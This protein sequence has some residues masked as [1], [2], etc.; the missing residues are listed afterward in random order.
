[1][2]NKHRHPLI[3][4][5]SG[6]PGWNSCFSFFSLNVFPSPA[7]LYNMLVLSEMFFLNLFFKLYYWRWMVKHE[8]GLRFAA[9]SVGDEIDDDLEEREP[10]NLT[11]DRIQELQGRTSSVNG[12]ISNVSKTGSFKSETVV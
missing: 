8:Y 3:N 10:M 4:L 11:H 2:G 6:G 1:M 5:G 7:V 12:S 9:A